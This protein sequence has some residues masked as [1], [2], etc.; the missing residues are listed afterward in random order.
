M[1]KTESDGLD[2]GDLDRLI[3]EITVDANGDDEGLMGRSLVYH[4]MIRPLHS[5]II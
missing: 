1:K 3:E 2:L 4:F 5:D